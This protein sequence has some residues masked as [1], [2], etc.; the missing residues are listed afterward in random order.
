MFKSKITKNHSILF[1]IIFYVGITK[2][3]THCTMKEKLQV[4]LSNSMSN[5]LT[6]RKYLKSYPSAYV[7]MDIFD[8]KYEEILV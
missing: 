8:E 6:I 4:S 3:L 1:E 2:R 7:I 5:N